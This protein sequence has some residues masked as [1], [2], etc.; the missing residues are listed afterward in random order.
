MLNQR[1]KKRKLWMHGLKPL[2]IW[3]L[4][5]VVFFVFLSISPFILPMG[6][7]Y[8][9]VCPECHGS[10][11]CW[12]CGGDGI[13]DYMPPESQWCAACHGSGKCYKCDGTGLVAHWMYSSF[14][15][16]IYSSWILIFSFLGLLLVSNVGLE[17]SLLFNDWVYDVE[18]MD[19]LG[20]PMFM[21]WLYATDRRRWIR[22]AVPM[23]ASAGILFGVAFSIIVFWGHI[24]QESFLVGSFFSILL[25]FLFSFIFYNLYT[26][27]LEIPKSSVRRRKKILDQVKI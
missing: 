16:T 2:R 25:L 17:T 24:T 19:F 8:D 5:T 22:W 27:W 13:I 7:T 12:V 3:I 10:G 20:N 18:G 4:F 9:K 6:Y 21:T 11:I 23:I 15:A 14:G 1:V 26:K